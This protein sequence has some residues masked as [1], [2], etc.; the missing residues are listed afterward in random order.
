MQPSQPLQMQQGVFKLDSS[1]GKSGEEK[2]LKNNVKGDTLS[3]FEARGPVLAQLGS[4]ESPQ[5]QE[6]QLI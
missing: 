6:S 3:H 1:K 5:L 2:T 4:P